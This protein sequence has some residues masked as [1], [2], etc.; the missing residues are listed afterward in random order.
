MAKPKPVPDWAEPPI[1][2]HQAAEALGFS[3]DSL[4]LALK[5]P[6]VEVGVHFELRGNRKVFYKENILEIR[7]VLIRCASNSQRGTAA[8]MSMGT[9][10]TARGTDALS[11][12]RMLAAQKN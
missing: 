8:T 7:K 1:D 10:P 12:L 2:I 9:A 3:R 11:K 5:D 4:D 6:G